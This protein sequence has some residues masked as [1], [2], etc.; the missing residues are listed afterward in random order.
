[1]AGFLNL[2][3]GG[4]LKGA[5]DA[6]VDKAKA[7]REAAIAALQ[8]QNKRQDMATEQDYQSQNIQHQGDIQQGLETQR[9]GFEGGENAKNREQQTN[10]ET[11]REGFEGGQTD[12]QIAAHHEDTSA[13]IAGRHEDVEAQANATRYVADQRRSAALARVDALNQQS[14]AGGKPLTYNQALTN[15]RIAYGQNV[16]NQ[17]PMVDAN[18]DTIPAEQWISDAAEKSMQ[19][20][21]SQP[22]ITGSVANNPASGGGLLI[23][24]GV[25]PPG[26]VGVQP[27]QTPQLPAASPS[28]AVAQP[29]DA[30]MASSPGSDGWTVQRITP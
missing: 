21:G 5:G 29:G 13:E 30:S 26:G 4:A 14:M 28:A 6:M 9:E 16:R 7:D 17:V 11:Q 20:F 15:A 2:M 10:L 1:M 27:Q 3:I 19:R 12:K 22:T 25:T 18:G 24:S 8:E 23:P